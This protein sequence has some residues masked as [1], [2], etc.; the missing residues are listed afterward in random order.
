MGADKMRAGVLSLREARRR[1]GRCRHDHVVIDEEKALVE[2]D[3]CGELLNPIYVLVK[4]AR[5][6]S[7]LEGRIEEQRVLQEKINSKLRTKCEHC[8]KMTRVRVR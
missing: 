1:L 2:C 8:G 4:F 5:E 7:V 6:E 3:D